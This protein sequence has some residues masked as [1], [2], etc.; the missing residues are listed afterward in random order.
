MYQFGSW[1]SSGEI[2]ECEIRMLVGSFDGFGLQVFPQTV[3]FG[4]LSW[5]R[6]AP[7]WWVARGSELGAR[8]PDGWHADQSWARGPDG[9]R[10]NRERRADTETAGET[11]ERRAQHR[12]QRPDAESAGRAGPS[13]ET[14]GPR[15]GAPDTAGPDTKSER[16]LEPDTE[17][18]GRAPRP[19]TESA[20]P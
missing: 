19:D 5:K 20:R 18:G 6:N 10:A 3:R 14:A 15:H 17:R 8:G 4:V 1:V 16:A 12:A 7:G 9:C 2:L 13:T 11:G